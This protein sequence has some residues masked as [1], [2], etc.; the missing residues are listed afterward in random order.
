M[1]KIS[2]LA[3]CAIATASV[4]S[5]GCMSMMLS[6]AATTKSFDDPPV[7]ETV[8][9]FPRETLIGKWSA[10]GKEDTFIGGKRA[11]AQDIRE[12]LELRDDGTCTSTTTKSIT[13]SKLGIRYSGGITGSD[14]AQRVTEGTWEYKDDV[15]KFDFSA[16]VAMGFFK[17]NVQWQIEQTVKWISDE[18]FMLCMD[19]KQF[20]ANARS[21]GGLGWNSR[22]VEPNGVETYVKKG[23]F[24][25][26]E[27]KS[28]SYI[29][30]YKRVG[31]AE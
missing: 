20:D 27:Q 10:T 6:G 29:S 22:T 19:E 26:P 1:K 15:I 3:A 30:P 2:A 21:M 12:D 18:E 5:T 4:L 14:E 31:D 17:R 16:E 13:E 9:S 24:M 28:I 8:D 23:G 25:S 11:M 7:R